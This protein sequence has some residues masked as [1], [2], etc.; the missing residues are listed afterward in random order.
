MSIGMQGMAKLE[1]KKAA[2]AA[3]SDETDSG[4]KRRLFLAAEALVAE[5]GFEAVSSRDITAAAEVN[6]AAINY[7]YGSKN[8]LLFEVF[9]AR[10]G[11]LNRERAALLS[12]AIARDPRDAPAILRAFI[13]PPTLWVSDERKTALRF[14]NRSR[15]EGPQE[16]RDVI[17][18][19]VRHLKLFADALITALPH[20]DREEVLWRL[21]FAQGVLHHNSAADYARLD[22]LSGGLCTPGDR[23]ALLDRLY[24]FI[25]AGFG[26]PAPPQT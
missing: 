1:V 10:A 6:V 19:D 21:H 16:I 4:A 13:E 12:A 9:K 20:L 5:R 15:S 25:A 17:L 2:G 3:N 26:L 8:K 7:Y 22:L 14:L 23:Q 18:K 24:H 11:E